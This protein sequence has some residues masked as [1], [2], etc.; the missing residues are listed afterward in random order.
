MRFHE[1]HRVIRRGIIG[2]NDFYS[3]PGCI[4]DGR[5]ELG[6]VRTA[7]PIEDHN[8]YRG[9]AQKYRK[10]LY[11]WKMIQALFNWR[12]L[13][14]IIAIGIVTGS[15]IYSDYL[16]QKLAAGERSKVE[17]WVEANKVI[18]GTNE[19]EAL[20]LA[21]SI[22]SGNTDIPIIATDERDSIVDWRN[23]DSIPG[24]PQR[25]KLPPKGTEGLPGAAPAHHLGAKQNALCI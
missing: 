25:Q 8:C 21:N 4:Q 7:V 18:A 17:E 5:Q 13:L 6:E 14:S 9:Q 15:I 2:H 12:S 1:G 3:W 20:N 10:G 19:R 23:L 16:S 24:W 11:I 22:S